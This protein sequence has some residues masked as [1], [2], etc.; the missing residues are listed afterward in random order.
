[1]RRPDSSSF[2]PATDTLEVAL[3][4][5]WLAWLLVVSPEP[6]G[7]RGWGWGTCFQQSCTESLC[8]FVWHGGSFS[9]RDNW[10][11][12]SLGSR[13]DR[14]GVEILTE[15]QSNN[16]RQCVVP[17]LVQARTPYVLHDWKT[18]NYWGSG[19][20]VLWQSKWDSYTQDFSESTLYYNS[21]QNI[22]CK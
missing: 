12:A 19:W 14:S 9:L 13:E 10:Y 4:G 17:S 11:P 15:W 6:S 5:G 20:Q 16:T 7:H 1:M 21:F 8:G 2:L 18:I 3:C 22:L